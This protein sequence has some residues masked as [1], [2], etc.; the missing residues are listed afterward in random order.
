MKRVTLG[1]SVLALST[2]FVLSCKPDK[3]V[4]PVA[5][6]E[7]QS[8]VYASYANYIASD[9]EMIC[10]YLGENTLFTHPYS[11]YPGGTS[12]TITPVR[13]TTNIMID[14]K[15]H[16]QLVLAWNNTRCKDGIVRDGSNIYVYP[17]SC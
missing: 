13:D 3:N 7:V 5:D 10:S 14:G 1:F 17:S 4:E 9:I 2:A 11:P 8:A 15:P 6:T 16:D 12:G